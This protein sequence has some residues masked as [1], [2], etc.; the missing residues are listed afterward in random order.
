MYNTCPLICTLYS[1][2]KGRM[3]IAQNTAGKKID[4][5]G[6]ICY[7]KHACLFGQAFQ[8][9]EQVELNTVQK[10]TILHFGFQ[11]TDPYGSKQKVV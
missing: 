3:L 7:I 5:N 8:V 10:Q 9:Q 4:R 11:R 2:L 1:C 6:S